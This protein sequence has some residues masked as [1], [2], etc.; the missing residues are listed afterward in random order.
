MLTRF[1]LLFAVAKQ[2]NSGLH[3]II[4]EVSGTHT[5]THTQGRTPLNEESAAT[6]TAHNKHNRRTSIPSVEFEP[7][8]PAIKRLQTYTLAA[9]PPG[10]AYLIKP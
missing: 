10:S 2:P 7:T 9:R 8:I 6:Y 3:H 1:Y 4:V 5:H